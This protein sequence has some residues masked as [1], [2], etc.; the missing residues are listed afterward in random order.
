MIDD[1]PGIVPE[2]PVEMSVNRKAR[3]R[4]RATA[5]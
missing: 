2:L 1:A 3:Q 4:T 5:S